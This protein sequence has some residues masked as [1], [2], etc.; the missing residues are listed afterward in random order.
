MKENNGNEKRFSRRS[1]LK[2][3]ALTGAGMMLSRSMTGV[4]QAA[5]PQENGDM[6]TAVYPPIL[7]Q[8]RV[9]GSGDAALEVSA[10]SLG[11]MGMN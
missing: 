5:E 8:K 10:L 7:T 6:K 1:F 3:A 2:T 11:C 9:L 4:L